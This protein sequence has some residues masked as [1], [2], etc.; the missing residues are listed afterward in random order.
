MLFP[1]KFQ[2]ILTFR[3]NKLNTA[4]RKIQKRNKAADCPFN[5]SLSAGINLVHYG[6][7]KP[8]RADFQMLY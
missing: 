2:D 3:G 7:I 8:I 4:V 1:P 6:N 5:V